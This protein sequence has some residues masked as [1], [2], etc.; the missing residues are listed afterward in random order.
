MARV[1]RKVSN[2][3][4]AG[5]RKQ[6]KF[7]NNRWFWIIVSV[8]VVIGLALGITLGIVLN[9]NTE[10]SVNKTDYFADCEQVEFV[11]GSYDGVKNYTNINY[12]NPQNNEDLFIQNVFI[13]AYDLSSF[14]PDS[15]DEDNYNKNHADI[16]SKL[17]DLQKAVDA[18]KAAGLEVELF[19]IDTSVGDNISVLDDTDFGGTEDSTVTFMF[20]Y[21]RNG[22]VVSDSITIRDKKYTLVSTS[23]N[24]MITTIIPQ[25]IH[26]VN[27]GLPMEE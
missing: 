3:A 16:L 15:D 23:L 19:I 5:Q 9:Q 21:I 2:R 26:F 24:D 7:F 10:E 1:V 27:D 20:T 17:I 18:A 6:K 14:Y 4:V 8:V 25:T 11:K 22:E 12:K 13:F